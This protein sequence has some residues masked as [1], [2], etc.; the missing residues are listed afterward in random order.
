M[1]KNNKEVFGKYETI[2]GD[3]VTLGIWIIGSVLFLLVWGAI[4][5]TF[6]F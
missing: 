6:I 4:L 2:D 5:F 1:K 3:F